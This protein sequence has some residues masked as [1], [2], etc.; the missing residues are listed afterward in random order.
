[1]HLGVTIQAGREIQIRNQRCGKTE[2]ED[3][4]LPDDTKSP[5]LLNLGVSA[6]AAETLRTQG[7]TREMDKRLDLARLHH[8]WDGLEEI[9]SGLPSVVAPKD[10]PE[11]LTL[12][13]SAFD[14]HLIMP[15]MQCVR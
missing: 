12:H 10:E 13:L 2:K 7:A 4:P 8:N 3:I 14:L 15:Q 9:R 1:M 11:V 5:V 6:T